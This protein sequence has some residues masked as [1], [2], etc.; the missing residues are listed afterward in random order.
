M[1]TTA[2][3]K[4]AIL[5]I[6]GKDL[7]NPTLVALA[8]LYNESW[9]SQWTV[10]ANPYDPEVAPAD[11]AAWPSNATNDE[12]ADFFAAKTR[13]E[14]QSRVWR[15]KK[16]ELAAADEAGQNSGAQAEADKL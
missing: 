12:I 10:G 6:A 2:E 9:G 8:T 7:D 13:S 3:V 11:H 16:A 4:T 15:A 14:W 5:S 1:A